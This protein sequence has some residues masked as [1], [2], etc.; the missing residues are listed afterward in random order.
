[1]VSRGYNAASTTQPA[2]APDARLPATTL[3]FGGSLG[4][5]SAGLLGRAA[6]SMTGC[7]PA[8]HAVIAQDVDAR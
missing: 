6:S 8:L 2:M 7:G 1:M 4:G 5:A 3:H